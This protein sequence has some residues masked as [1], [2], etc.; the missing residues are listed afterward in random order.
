MPLTR[1]PRWLLALV[2]LFISAPAHAVE[3]TGQI[4]GMVMDEGGLGVPNVSVV[5]TSPAL[6]GTA[7]AT[8][9]ASGDFRLAALPPGAYLV[10]VEAPGF[11]VW[12][13]SGV[14]VSGGSTMT[15]EV[16]LAS[17]TAGVEVLVEAE[18][19]VVDL[20]NT[21]T[22][23]TLDANFLKD[24]PS[25]ARDYQSVVAAAPGVVG[26]GNPNMHGGFDISNQ[27]Y[28][29]GVNIT[30]P[31]TNTFSMNMNYDA[32]EEIQVITGGMDAEYGRAL[33]G[34]VNIITK[35]GGNQFEGTATVY[36]T[37]ENF[38]A[39]EPLP[40]EETEDV[41]FQ[42]F[43]ANLNLG[44]PIVKDKVWFFTALELSRY[45]DTAR[46]DPGLQRPEG[47]DPITGEDMSFVAPR[48]WKSLYWFAKV[49]AQPTSKHRVWLHAQG[50][51]T[52][53]DN[54]AQSPYTLPSAESDVDQGG[55]LGSLGHIFM[56]GP[57]LHVESQAYI[58]RSY[59]YYYPSLWRDCTEF[60]ENGACLDVPTNP[61]YPTAWI[62][63]GAVDF[64]LGEAAY[65]E[66]SERNRYSL[67]STATLFLSDLLGEHKVK[68]GVQ[69]ELLQ[70]HYV[71]PGLAP[72]CDDPESRDPAV[73]PDY[74]AGFQ[75]WASTE[76]PTD[77]STYV[78][79]LLIQYDN[80]QD[81]NLSGLLLSAFVQDVWQPIPRLTLRPGL[82]FDQTAMINDVGERVF[83]GFG[84][85]PRIGGAFDLTGDRK[86]SVHAYYG[87][88]YDTAFLGVADLLV[89]RSDGYAYYGWDS[90]ANGG[91]GAWDF[92]D[93]LLEV[94]S[95][96]LVHDQLKLPYSD[97]F[98]VGL[99]RAMGESVALDLTYV[100]EVGHNFYEDDE[101]N[102]IWD[103]EGS[104]VIGYRNGTN[105]AI[106]RL[107]TSDDLY[108]RYQSLETSITKQWS[109]HWGMTGSYTWS[110]A[111]GN[112]G[113]DTRDEWVATIG[114]D[115]PEQEQY[116]EGYLA[117]DRT[118][119]F[120]L[121]G[122]YRN[123]D[124]WTLGDRASAGWM[125]GWN[126][127]LASG[128]PYRPLYENVEFGGYY[129][130]AEDSSDPDRLPAVSQLDLKAGLL[131]QAGRAQ[132]ALYGECFN[133]FNDRTATS[134]EEVAGLGYG[135]PTSRQSPRY[136]RL[137][138]RGEF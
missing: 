1:F 57:Q 92:E 88:F 22:G 135:T 27:Y 136:F 36:Y 41:E 111:W 108:T 128:Y 40:D 59:L 89:D 12:Q 101:V 116:L 91:A 53:I 34:A 84:V 2:L 100:H 46:L 130:Y 72:T 69:A 3:L 63:D 29:N 110:K 70:A 119:Y 73:C 52:F 95:N 38:E 10:R 106:Y 124:T 112:K 28:I 15:L 56:A 44:G 114:Y 50:D 82:R 77:L 134:V 75:Y 62:G 33:G 8:T 35:S 86:T 37:D 61:E 64:A 23:L 85:A 71:R 45:V 26:A 21:R 115:I 137:G 68:V 20:Q 102:L 103:A 113:T 13:V 123:P 76:D 48:D 79:S 58:Q 109:E 16:N 107:R 87:R 120:K 47:P 90:E 96:F 43:T 131:L 80:I 118:H 49:T 127:F 51:P 126:Y 122:S 121:L 14:R 11:N 4:V 19:P 30:D 81:T 42:E 17:A 39:F 32:I 5:A 7:Q 6:Q 66:L 74:D 94:S 54:V 133:V 132:F 25:G 117:Y 99:T 125:A 18:A 97:D 31:L 60:D 67:N 129:N 55:W 98:N 104:E 9:S 93:P 24:L 105:E 83:S 65:A 78:P 138:L